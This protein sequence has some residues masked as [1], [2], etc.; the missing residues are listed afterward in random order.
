MHNGMILMEF[1]PMKAQ[2]KVTPD[3]LLKKL[4]LPKLNLKRFWPKDTQDQNEHYLRT[5]DGRQIEFVLWQLKT[6]L[7]YFY[8]QFK[9][10][11]T[12]R[13][14]SSSWE[15]PMLV[16]GYA[17]K[18]SKP[19]YAL[20]ALVFGWM[21]TFTMEVVIHVKPLAILDYQRTKILW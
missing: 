5:R 13:M 2:F 19:F 16:K 12:R 21:V 11:K 8:S 20:V 1:G 7:D 3:D 17:P 10:L 14:Q 4:D 6:I 15:L 18:E 9:N